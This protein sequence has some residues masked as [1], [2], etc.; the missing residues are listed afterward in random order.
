MA[1]A[2]EESDE[3]QLVSVCIL[4]RHGAR[5][6]TENAVRSLKQGLPEDSGIPALD[7]WPTFGNLTSVG[8]EEMR[9]LGT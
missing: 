5:A 2:C 8:N 6:I 1:R 7:E 4:F 9:N 3:R